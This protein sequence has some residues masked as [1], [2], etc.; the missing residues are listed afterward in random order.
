MSPLASGVQPL[1]VGIN[2]NPSTADNIKTYC[3]LETFGA[4][5]WSMHIFM[6]A[7]INSEKAAEVDGRFSM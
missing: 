7:K 2:L 3:I 5:S 6:M 1:V 4:V